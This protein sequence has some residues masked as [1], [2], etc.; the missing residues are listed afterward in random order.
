MIK[1]DTS[2]NKKKI[3][4]L[5]NCDF[6][7][8]FI[9]QRL[10]YK[11]RLSVDAELSTNFK[12]IDDTLLRM[13]R[14][15]FLDFI[16]IEHDEKIAKVN[17]ILMSTHIYE[18]NVILKISLLRKINLHV[19]WKTSKWQLWDDLESSSTKRFVKN[20]KQKSKNRSIKAK[21]FYITQISWNKLQFNLSKSKTF[22]F[23]ILFDQKTSTN[24][25]QNKNVKIKN[26][27]NITN[28][29]SFQYTKFR[30]LFSKMNA[31]KLFE[32]DFEN[33]VIKTLF[34]RE[35]FFDSI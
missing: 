15:Y 22:A 23:A 32:H 29:M 26:N 1:F 35:F 21:T 24:C 3:V 34:D 19:N 11:W 8:N 9:D 18:M 2:T 33:H 25:I 12:T 4:A 28:E 7:Q 20:D 10:A 13:F 6:N 14:T 27:E 31:H 30:D 5:I 17:Q 16:S